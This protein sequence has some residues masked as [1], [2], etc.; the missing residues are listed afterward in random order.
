MKSSNLPIKNSLFRNENFIL[1]LIG[2]IVSNLGNAIHSVS[3]VWYILSLVGENRSG[4][5]IA[6]FTMCT[7]IPSISFGPI[8][9]VYVDKLDRKK[10]IW[11]TDLI[12]GAL[13]LILGI[14]TYYKVF[15]LIFL[16]VI[17]ALNSFFGTFFNPAVDS[18]I[19]N[20]V[21]EKN[22]MTA[23]SVNG[24]SRQVVFIFGAAI[25]GFLYSYIGIV[26][27]F[28]VN[29]ISFILSGISEM[30]IKLQSSKDN[31]GDID[32]VTFWSDF[33]GGINYVKGQKL[34]LKLLGFALVLNFLISPLFVVIFPKAIKFTLALGAREYGLFQAVL[35]VG[36]VVGMFILPMLPKRE[37]NYKL[38]HRSLMLQS[39]IIAL[40][41]IPI[42][43][44]IYANFTNYSVFIMFCIL[45]FVLMIFNSLVNVPIFT[46]FQKRVP[47][48]YRG[49]FFGML[50]TLTQ[51]I[52]PLGLM[53]MGFLSDI[54]H[55]SVIFIASGLISFALTIW[56]LFI[57]GFKE[58]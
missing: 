12:R 20:I 11:G 38:I 43:P 37:K 41:G 35:S 16:F 40:F 31:A 4:I 28:L 15:P 2:Q 53:V 21:D 17:T 55:S 26:G 6:V 27:I 58:L 48:E 23:N 18:S 7:L 29:G 33:K 42:I 46:I 1:L 14:F 49:R 13:I 54:L 51:G 50:N 34:I 47:D 36:A 22:L 30:F 8:S 56:M 32:R 24:I 9:G 57:P 25:A 44:M 19:P 5:F 45:S 10:I 52:V 3:V 39:I